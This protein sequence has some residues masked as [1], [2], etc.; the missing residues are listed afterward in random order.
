[1]YTTSHQSGT[2][3]DGNPITESPGRWTT[4][5]SFELGTNQDGVLSTGNGAL[6]Q[7]TW[8]LDRQG[9]VAFSLKVGEDTWIN[10]L[11]GQD[12]SMLTGQTGEIPA[13][14]IR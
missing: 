4:Q 5:S 3:T 2:A 10:R 11:N 6:G 14:G 13:I 12:L 9:N 8:A 1:V 7:I